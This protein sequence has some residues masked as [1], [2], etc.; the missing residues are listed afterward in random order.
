MIKYIEI[1]CD[2]VSFVALKIIY[3]TLRKKKD[4]LIFKKINLEGNVSIY[5]VICYMICS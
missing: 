3:E 5:W 2:R 4:D 1:V